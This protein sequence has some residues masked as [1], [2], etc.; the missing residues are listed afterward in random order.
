MVRS[1]QR[2]SGGCRTVA[3]LTGLL[4]AALFGLGHVL[5]RPASAGEGPS[6]AP[7]ARLQLTVHRR[8]LSVDLRD[9]EVAE[10]LARLGQET[11]VLITGSPTSAER[12]SAQFADV[13]LEVGLRR[14]LRLTSLSHA[15][16][17]ARGP[18]E[19]MSVRE[20]RVFTSVPEGS[21]SRPYET[22]RDP[23]ARAA[24]SPDSPRRA[25]S[26]WPVPPP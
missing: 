5:E 10:V 7:V 2:R 15:I 13:E 25:G 6:G 18:T 21:L 11:G 9:T 20:V 8:R 26:R 14:L 19:A 23:E 12:V 17:Y 3:V 1:H 4:M 16:R 24:S 22:A